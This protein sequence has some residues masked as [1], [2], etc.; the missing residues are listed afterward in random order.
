[1]RRLS[2]NCDIFVSNLTR[3]RR[4]RYGL[5]WEQLS[6][7]NP[8]IVYASL[9]GYGS[10][11]PDQDRSGFDYAAFWARSGIMGLL[12]EPGEPPPSCRAGQGDHSTS[13]N[14]LAAILVGLRLR[15]STGEAQHVEVTLQGSGMWTIASDLSATLMARES[16]PRMSRKSPT[17]PLRNVYQCA[18][19]RWVLLVNAQPFP[20]KWPAFCRMLGHP[21]WAEP[22]RWDSWDSIIDNCGTIVALVDEI[23]ST[24]DFAHWSAEL[25]RHGIIWA[26]VATLMEVV[27]DPQVHAMGWIK[28]MEGS[29][30]PI[31]TLD[32]PFKV[33][34][35]DTGPRGPAPLPGQHT[36][37]V[38]SEFG[39]TGDELD[40]LATDGVFG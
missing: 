29:Y 1:V 5:G 24:H 25:D 22:G 27:N 16:P 17:H 10:E 35:S 9:T 21:E 26:P 38:L 31:E 20:H 39:I 13:L 3:G 19:G 2:E 15:D 36:F 14:F 18:D 12:G 33:Y 28:E 34:G 7:L 11:G 37:D 40:R 4:D 30:G 6:T 23:M 32:T 8:R